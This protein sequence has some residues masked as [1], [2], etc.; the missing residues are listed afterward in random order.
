MRAY[1]IAA[2]LLAVTPLAAQDLAS[3]APIEADAERLACYD[4]LSGRTAL[5]QAEATK[6]DRRVS[7]WEQR[8]VQNAER[9]PFTLTTH[10]PNY[11]L[12]THLST[13]NREP[14]RFAEEADRLRDDEAKMHL[15]MQFKAANDLIA[16][17]GDLWFGYSQ[18]AYWQ[19]LSSDISSPFREVDH[20]PEAYL[21]FLTNYPLLGLTGRSIGV[22]F[23]HHSN[24]LGGPLSRSWN[25]VFADFAFVRGDL[26]LTVRPWLRLHEDP[27]DDDNPDIERYFGNYEVRAVWEKNDH[28]LSLMLRNVFDSEGRYGAE[29][30]W[31]FPIAG[32]LRGLVQW[33]NGYGENLIDYNHK[34]NRIGV[35]LLISDWL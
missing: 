29:L 32:R 1:V 5:A 2:L 31:S 10:R 33:Y 18:T 8:L 4:A 13:F 14:Y 21:S 19:V 28:V 11:L 30:S 35:G 22:G 25:R 12:Y 23:L 16:G 15:S 6:P 24:G 7:V 34:N 27:E 3:C 17:D 26:A 9:E 20:E